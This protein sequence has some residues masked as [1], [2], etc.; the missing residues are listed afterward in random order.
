MEVV[1]HKVGGWRG[2]GAVCQIWSRMEVVLRKVGRWGGG[3][4][5]S[6]PDLVTDGGS[7]TQGGWME[8]LQFA[9]FGHGWMKR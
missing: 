9:R 8:G 3:G 4:G 7:T 6:L 2:G 1:L 5:C